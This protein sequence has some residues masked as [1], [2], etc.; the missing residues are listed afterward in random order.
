M[1]IRLI[2]VR[3]SYLVSG[4]QQLNMFE[5]TPEMVRLY[6]TMDKLRNRF[7]KYAIRRAVGVKT[8]AEAE[9]FLK[10]KAQANVP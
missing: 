5:D 8:P 7:G 1:M 10:V 6:L 3:F 4:G 9:I 2:G